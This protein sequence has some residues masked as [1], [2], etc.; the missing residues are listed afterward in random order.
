[1]GDAY[2]SLAWGGKLAQEAGADVAA[3]V[4]LGD[5]EALDPVERALA[6]WARQVA[7]DPN[8][9]TAADV[10]ALRDVGFDDDQVLAVTVFVALR[11]AFSG[12]NDAL[13]ALPDRE[14]VDRLPDAVRSAVTF[15]R[16]VET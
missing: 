2:C 12:V 1:M 11:L 16:P 13:G 15:G 4:L 7:R 6:R 10:Q 8:A 5:D 3:S 14:L 9:T